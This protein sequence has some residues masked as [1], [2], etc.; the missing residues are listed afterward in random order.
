M[1]STNLFRETMRFKCLS[2]S[3]L[4]TQELYEV[5][6]LRQEVFIVEQDCPYLDADGKDQPAWH[7]MG[8]DD[9]QKLVAYTRLLDKG[10][11]Y[12]KYP[13]IGRV[14]TSPAARG[15]GYGVSLM[16]ESIKQIGT[17]FGK[18]DI[19]ISAQVYLD[20]FYRSLGFEPVGEG[21]LEDNI[22]HIAMI[23]RAG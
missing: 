16:K 2:F 22:P 20:Q 18:Q 4:S 15:K 3:Q 5:M 17:L 10:I 13:S 11:S 12:P 9:N 1:T 23:W 21:Y 6:A 14:V 8:F 7:L 19:K